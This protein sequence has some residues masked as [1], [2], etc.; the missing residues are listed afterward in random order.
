MNLKSDKQMECGKI[1]NALR[2]LLNDAKGGVYQHPI[3]RLSK[4]K[5][6][7]V[8]NL[9]QEKHP[10][11]QKSDLKYVVTDLRNQDLPFHPIFEKINV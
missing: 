9:L 1:S 2:C 3:N 6:C 10:C 11:S 5:N 7:T 8:H 4:E